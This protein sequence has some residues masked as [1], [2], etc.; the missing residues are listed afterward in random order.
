V[1][2]ID[3][4][5]KADSHEADAQ[6]L[7]GTDFEDLKRK[8]RGICI[9]L[10]RPSDEYD[11][12]RTIASIG[13]YAKLNTRIIYSEISAYVF[14]LSDAEIGDFVTNIETLLIKSRNDENLPVQVRDDILKI[15]DHVHLALYQV[16]HLKRDD[17]ELKNII[18]RNLE[19]VKER[20]E[21]KIE[22]AYK[23][24]YAQLIALIGIFTALAFLVFGSISV[25]D[26]VFMKADEMPMLKIMMIACIWGICLT[27]LIFIFI[28]FVARLTKLEAGEK[29]TEYPVVAWCNLILITILAVCSWMYYVD[30]MEL[31]G[32][33]AKLAKSNEEWVVIAG[34]LVIIVVFLGS[35]ITLGV[36]YRRKDERK[37]DGE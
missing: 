28:Y 7:K 4:L 13:R 23:E 8:M 34:F 14:S 35:A 19:P 31:T 11:S 10:N 37:T 25:L 24:I 5:L 21:G 26:N 22:S 1:R 17:E 27:N 32:W 9:S 12:G 20:F 29:G 33:L 15:Y 30:G 18:G 3:K 36:K 6:K 2:K 16:E